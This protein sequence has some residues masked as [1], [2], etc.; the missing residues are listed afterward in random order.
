MRCHTETGGCMFDYCGRA[1]DISRVFEGTG[2]CRACDQSLMT[3][4]LTDAIFQAILTSDLVRH[5]REQSERFLRT[6][7]CPCGGL[8]HPNVVSEAG[9]DECNA[10]GAGERSGS[11]PTAIAIPGGSKTLLTSPV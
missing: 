7:L 5:Q 4:L 1:E 8:R 9:G 3:R 2:L 11:E 6:W 10:E